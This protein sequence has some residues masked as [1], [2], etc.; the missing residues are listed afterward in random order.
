MDVTLALLDSWDR[1]A[2]MVSALAGLVTEGN[3]HL[4]PSEDGMPLSA[5]LAHMHQVRRYWIGEL[6]KSVEESLP[7]AYSDGWQTPIEDLELIKKMLDQSAQ[8]VRDAVAAALAAGK[9]KVGGYDNPVL[10]LQHMVWH[11]GW[12]V[13]LI[14]L[15]LR[16]GGQEPTEEWEEQHLW[17]EWRTEVW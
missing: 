2:R 13:G 6:D 5:Q 7:S 15:S 4:K 14:M 12:H 16:L 8:A 17:G 3:R 9:E 1:Q 11:E 10:Y